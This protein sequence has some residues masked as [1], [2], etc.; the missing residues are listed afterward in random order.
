MFKVS[1][2]D[3]NNKVLVADLTHYFVVCNVDLE[4]LN[5]G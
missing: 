3:D 2:K 4:Q 5:A 1:N